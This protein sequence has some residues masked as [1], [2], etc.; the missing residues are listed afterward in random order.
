MDMLETGNGNQSGHPKIKGPANMTVTEYITEFSMWAIA[1]SPLLVT[2]PIMKCA[3]VTEEVGEGG[4]WDE[5]EGWDNEEAEEAAAA[6]HAKGATSCEVSLTKQLSKKIECVLGK[7]FGCNDDGATMW[8]GPLPGG[9]KSRG[10]RGVFKCD[11]KEGIKCGNDTPPGGTASYTCSCSQTPPGPSPSPSPPIDPP[12]GKCVGALT[13]VQRMIL[14]NTEVCHMSGAVYSVYEWMILLN[15]EVCQLVNESHCL[16]SVL[17]CTHTHTLYMHH[18][19]TTHLIH[20]HTLY[21]AHAL[22][23]RGQ[24]GFYP[25][26]RADR[27]WRLIRLVA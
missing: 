7:T 21:T 27:G 14:L 8:V 15:T 24:P 1:A 12:K 6:G 22:G 17:L 18:S 16:L 9:N 20:S 25:T 13:D 10:C 4:G 5:G 26:R 19:Y 23:H 11:G 2:T 3:G